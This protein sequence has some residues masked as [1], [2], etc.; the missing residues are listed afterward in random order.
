MEGIDRAKQANII[1]GSQA[2]L[3]RKFA[4]GI[5]KNLAGATQEAF[6]KLDEQTQTAVMAHHALN[7]RSVLISSARE[8]SESIPAQGSSADLDSIIRENGLSGTDITLL[9]RL[10]SNKTRKID[11]RTL[12]IFNRLD[13]ASKA[14][15]IRLYPGLKACIV[16]STG[17]SESASNGDMFAFLMERESNETWAEKVFKGSN[18]KD[19]KHGGQMRNAFH[20]LDNGMQNL[21]RSDCDPQEKFDA[22][23][24]KIRAGDIDESDG[25]YLKEI[26]QVDQIEK[27]REAGRVT[28]K[29]AGQAKRFVEGFTRNVREGSA[30]ERAIFKL[31]DKTLASF[32]NYHQLKERMAKEE[33]KHAEKEKEEREAKANKKT[34]QNCANVHASIRAKAI[35]HGVLLHQLNQS[36]RKAHMDFE[37]VS[38]AIASS[39]V[40]RRFRQFACKI[41]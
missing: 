21:L 36:R 11:G 4:R 28:G 41:I 1:T 35:Q 26:V 27:D 9:K 12:Q 13:D 8:P 32:V 14:N 3:L 15:L 24:A 33:K 29:E 30:T 39:D 38:E 34:T 17:I 5:T 10:V 16:K 19:L 25:Q 40:E 22:I 18:G 20:R 23:D 37:A 6:N 2:G 31:S 7:T